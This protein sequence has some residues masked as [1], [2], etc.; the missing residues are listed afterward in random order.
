MDVVDEWS[1]RH[2][3]ALQ[4]AMRATNEEFARRLGVAVRT[5]ASWHA[6][7]STVPR[8]EMQ[9]ALDTL[10]E[11]VTQAERHR[12]AALLRTDV[13]SQAQALKVA[14]A[15]V[16]RGAEVLLV[17]RRGEESLSWGFPAGVVKPGG[18]SGAVAVQ[19]T[20]AETAV[21]CSVRQHLGSRV[22]PTTGV[23]A[24]YEFCEYLAGEVRNAD[25]LEN[26]D[27]TWVPISSLTKFIPTER[28]YPPALEALEALA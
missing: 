17:C 14:I 15:I 9:R 4:A 21:H 20:L 23:L 16:A 25:P 11:Q 13:G 1:G 3:A 28:I 2:A 8:R 10:H 5:V 26:L 27:A 19:E 24:S 22:H 18:S 12:F 6:S 7:P